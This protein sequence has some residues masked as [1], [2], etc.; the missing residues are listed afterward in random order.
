MPLLLRTAWRTWT[1]TG[2][3]ARLWLLA[4]VVE[5]IITG[6]AYWLVIS[7]AI[8]ALQCFQIPNRD[9]LA[10]GGVDFVVVA[11]SLAALM[12]VGAARHVIE[13]NLQ[14]HLISDMGDLTN[15]VVDRLR[16]DVLDDNQFQATYGVTLREA[17]LRLFTLSTGLVRFLPAVAGAIAIA[18]Q[19][20]R[21]SAPLTVAF[22]VGSVPVFIADIYASRLMVRNLQK[23]AKDQM[24]MQ[25]L[26][27]YQVDPTAQRDLRIGARGLMA[28][29][30][31]AVR[32]RYMRSVLTAGGAM[33]AARLLAAAFNLVFLVVVT[34]AVLYALSNR[35]ISVTTLAVF[36]PAA[37]GLS[38]Q[39]GGVSDNA[40]RMYEG[41]SILGMVFG[42]ETLAKSDE[43][44]S[45]EVAAPVVQGRQ[46]GFRLREVSYEYPTSRVVGL[47]NISLDLSTGLH[48]VMGSNGSGKS[49][50]LKVMSGL[51]NPTTGEVLRHACSV[52]TLFQEPTHLP[53]TVLQFVTQQPDAG[54][55][56]VERAW[57]ALSRIGLA[58]IV[59]ALPN[60][61]ETELGVGFG[62]DVELSGGQWK[63]L[64]IARALYRDGGDLILDE[65]ETGLDIDGMHLLA[66]EIQQ[67]RR[68]RT[69]VIATHMPGLMRSADQIYVMSES[70]LVEVGS[71]EELAD[72]PDGLYRSLVARGNL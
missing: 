71:H 42:M 54:Q 38:L 11:G 36:I 6:L 10:C 45:N 12:V 40:A 50:L 70:Q 1:I 34:G 4:A 21:M 14:V 15:N 26:M 37:Y 43:T 23:T 44:R 28:A 72:R 69:V 35:Q 61:L 51:L 31:R 13:L 49:T 48:V 57:C 52:T 30:Y 39:L 16:Y 41:L 3:R 56:D 33:F 68:K 64:A 65:P 63:R 19:L 8:G 29:L 25:L 5:A 20:F 55:V 22:I 67:L 7:H 9:I 58:G 2:K 24:R 32:E 66:A 27:R 60:K 17:P 47:R 46:S 59:E 18:L 62:G 53:L